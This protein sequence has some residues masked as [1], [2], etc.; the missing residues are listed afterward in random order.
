MFYYF[1]VDWREI[2]VFLGSAIYGMLMS[3]SYIKT[4]NEKNNLLYCAYFVMLLQGLLKSFVRW[5]FVQT[6]YILSFIYI[7]FMIKKKATGK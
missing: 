1:Y 4:K 3:I 5:E 2:G 7:L 6:S